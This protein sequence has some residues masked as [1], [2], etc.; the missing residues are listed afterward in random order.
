MNT[1]R[2][3][4]LAS[5]VMAASAS[6]AGAATLTQVPSIAANAASFA[7]FTDSA[8]TFNGVTVASPAT[9]STSTPGSTLTFTSTTGTLQRYST[10]N[11]LDNNFA[12]GTQFIAPCDL[13]GDAGCSTSATIRITFSVP[14]AGFTISADDFDTL[15]SHTFTATAFNGTTSLGSITA[16]SLADNGQSPA[17]L[18][19]F[20]S[21]PVT[22]VVVGD[23]TGNFVLAS[24]GASTGAN[25]VPEPASLAMLAG[26]VA[27]LSGFRRRTLA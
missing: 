15:A 21:V 9:Y 17:I 18:A 26:S 4:L 11:Y 2:T 24:I 22:S 14:A 6:T 16:S 12:N 13:Y 1:R 20:S 10:A 19:A 3:L 8:G 7:A 23:S 27:L 5:A 25:A